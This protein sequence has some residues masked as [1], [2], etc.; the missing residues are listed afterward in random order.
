MARSPLGVLIVEEKP[1]DGMDLEEAVV[2]AGHQV[3]GWATNLPNAMA[4]VEARAPNVAFVSPHLRDG[5]TGMEVARR[6]SERGINV[7]ITADHAE[8]LDNLESVLGVMPK[9]FVTE[10]VQQVLHRAAEKLEG[11]DGEPSVPPL[12]PSE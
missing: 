4:L 11:G 7:V 3:T 1:L 8:P 2:L 5:D 6:L 10:T 12:K 9:P